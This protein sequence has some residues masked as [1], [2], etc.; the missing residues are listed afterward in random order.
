MRRN[1]N[2]VQ[3]VYC[4]IRYL[5]QCYP[6]NLVWDCFGSTLVEVTEEKMERYNIS[7][8]PIN[9]EKIFTTRAGFELT[10]STTPPST[11]LSVTSTNCSTETTQETIVLVAL[12]WV[13]DNAVSSSLCVATIPFANESLSAPSKPK[14]HLPY[15]LNSFLSIN[16]FGS[17]SIHH[18]YFP[19]IRKAKFYTALYIAARSNL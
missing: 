16:D 18:V 4:I 3:D 6:N 1:K 7:T 8:L 19:W 13:S 12:T 10:T 11:A 2:S 9:A 5:Y 17:L 14:V 15:V